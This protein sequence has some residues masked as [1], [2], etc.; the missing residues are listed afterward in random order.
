VIPEVLVTD[1]LKAARRQARAC[2]ARVQE[3]TGCHMVAIVAE[4]GEGRA[5]T[6]MAVD[7]A[8]E[9][10]PETEVA[11]MKCALARVL[12]LLVLHL[13]HRGAL[14]AAVEAVAQGAH[15]AQ[16]AHEGSDDSA[17]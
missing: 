8:L 10:A 14:A 11:L 5:C 12:S 6:S 16:L 17:G 4:V 13:G 2:A 15:L 3:E 7:A 1:G 9:G